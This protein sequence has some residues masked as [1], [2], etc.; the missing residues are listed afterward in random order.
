MTDKEIVQALRCCA[1][2]ECKDCAMHE[3]KQRCQEN[4]LDK[5][6]DLIERLTA[7]S[8]DL[9]KEIEWKDMVIDLAQREQAKA[10]AERDALIEQIKERLDCRGCKYNDFCDFDSYTVL[11][12][13]KCV[14]EWCPCP[15]CFDS[16]RWEW[17]GLQKA[18]EEGEKA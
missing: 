8:A 3:D 13:M 11:D 4:L 5:A 6:A 18:P 7:E 10:E 14:Q 1:E 9:R 12:C 16:R 2:G 17:R 15:G